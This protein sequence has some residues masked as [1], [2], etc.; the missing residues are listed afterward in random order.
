MLQAIGWKSSK[1][2]VE[3]ARSR[4]KKARRKHQQDLLSFSNL[5]HADIPEIILQQADL[6]KSRVEFNMTES[7]SFKLKKSEVRNPI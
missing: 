1:T 2:L 5:L 4:M 3:A 6:G 7:N